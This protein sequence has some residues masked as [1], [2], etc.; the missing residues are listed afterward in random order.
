MA[1]K[2]RSCSGKIRYGDQTGAVRTIISMKK[3]GKA[4][5]GELHPYKCKFCRKW[6]IGHNPKRRIYHD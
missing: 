2:R 1:S 4:A 5:G 6:H 3:A